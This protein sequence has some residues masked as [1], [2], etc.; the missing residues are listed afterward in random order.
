MWRSESRRRLETQRELLLKME[1]ELLSELCQPW[2]ACKSEQRVA[3]DDQ[4]VVVRDD[5]ASQQASN[6]IYERI[7]AIE[8]ALDLIAQGKYGKCVDC[9]TP[10]LSNR[11]DVL[12]WAIRCSGCE[13]LNEGKRGLSACT[14]QRPK[15]LASPVVAS[16]A[17]R[18]SSS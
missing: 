15:P 10:I 2:E 8:A 6:L 7:K 18:R 14:P 1:S 5:S 13:Q 3:V 16:P 12:P 17:V 4:A 9:G 11:L